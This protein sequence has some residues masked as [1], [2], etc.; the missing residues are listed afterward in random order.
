M[1]RL[2]V[3]YEKEKSISFG[4]ECRKENTVRQLWKMFRRRKSYAEWK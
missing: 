1:S 4:E 3:G 2:T